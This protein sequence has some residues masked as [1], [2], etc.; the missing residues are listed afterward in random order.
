MASTP[1]PAEDLPQPPI[2]GRRSRRN[3]P[4]SP[5]GR[6]YRA[7]TIG[8]PCAIGIRYRRRRAVPPGTA[9]R[10][11]TKTVG[12][13]PR[14]STS[15]A[16]APSS[17]APSAAARPEH[18][19][20]GPARRPDQGRGRA[21]RSAAG[22]ATRASSGTAATA[23]SSSR[24]PAASARRPASG[25]TCTTSTGT[26]R[27][28][29]LGRGVPQRQQRAGASRP[30]RPAPDRTA[31]AGRGPPR[32]GHQARATACTS[33]DVGGQPGRGGQVVVAE[34]QQLGRPAQP[35]QHPHRRVHRRVGRVTSHAGCGTLGGG[36]RLLDD[37]VAARRAPSAPKPVTRPR[38]GPGESVH[39]PQLTCRGRPPPARPAARRPGRPTCR[40]ADDDGCRT[41]D[42]HRSHLRSVTSQYTDHYLWCNGAIRLS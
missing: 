40:D 35:Q 39:H 9:P 19:Q 27:R 22:C 23:A 28:R 36:D 38:T 13:A 21:R 16:T 29:R 30:P 26:P 32:T 5:P 6:S 18:D 34:H 14:R 24:G 12:Q 1:R 2:A 7:S 4:S 17:P 42:P 3:A 37:R 10:P 31:A 8:S 11:C 20:P 25:T 41:R 33:T 15:R